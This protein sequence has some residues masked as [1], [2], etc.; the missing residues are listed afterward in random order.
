VYI[1]WREMS[2]EHAA[3]V[4]G[5][6]AGTEEDGKIYEDYFREITP[7]GETVWEFSMTELP[8]ENYPVSPGSR[9][10]EFGHANTICPTPD[11]NL[12]VNFRNLDLMAII[13][14]QQ[15]RF[16]WEKHDIKW[17]RGHDPQLLDNGNILFFA[18]GA[19]DLTLP[20][21][22][23]IIEL[24]RHSGE[25]VWR[26]EAGI[27]HRAANDAGTV[28]PALTQSPSQAST[29]SEFACTQSRATSSGLRPLPEI[30]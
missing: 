21:R 13:D 11:G 25:D 8:I 14:K 22:S 2:P 27:A 15:R 1:G 12:L 20:M 10:S 28:A 29:R 23:A 18:N 6:I 4:Q 16:V 26:Y 3:R 9:R 19:Q 17:G 30:S 24:D 7:D 5:G